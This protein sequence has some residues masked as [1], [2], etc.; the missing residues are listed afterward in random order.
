MNGETCREPL[1]VEDLGPD[2]IRHWSKVTYRI[3]EAHNRKASVRFSYRGHMFCLS[4][5]KGIK[6]TTSTT[7]TEATCFKRLK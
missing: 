3:T 5:S 7:V 4:A 2:E 1:Q 6:E